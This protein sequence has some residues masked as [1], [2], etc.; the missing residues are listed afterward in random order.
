MKLKKEVI[1]LVV[2]DTTTNKTVLTE[3]KFEQDRSNIR[4][5]CIVN[6]RNG[7]NEE[8]F[9]KTKIKNE[10]FKKKTKDKNQNR[11]PSVRKMQLVK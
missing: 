8:F 2:T 7:M 11:D 5:S 1:E 6:R 9:I 4:D 10:K 3:I